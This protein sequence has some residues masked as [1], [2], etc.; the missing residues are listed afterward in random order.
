VHHG[1][2]DTQQWTRHSNISC[3]GQVCAKRHDVYAD[4][5]M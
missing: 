2:S 4:C 5:G 3:R 1:T